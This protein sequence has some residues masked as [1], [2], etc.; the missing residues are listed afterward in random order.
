MSHTTNTTTYGAQNC[1]HCICAVNQDDHM[2]YAAVLSTGHVDLKS[3]WEMVG[4]YEKVYVPYMTVWCC[5]CRRL[6]LNMYP[7]R[8][9]MSN[10][11]DTT[12]YTCNL[13]HMFKQMPH[14][15]ESLGLSD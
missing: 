5:Q 11:I 2:S 3:F 1:R 7:V 12:A 14:V 9:T 6:S 15:R 10:S 8:D 4:E 13:L